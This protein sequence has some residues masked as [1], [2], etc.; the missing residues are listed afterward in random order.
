MI[1]MYIFNVNWF[2]LFKFVS[3][4][5]M[6]KILGLSKIYLYNNIGDE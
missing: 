5:E 4:M 1:N 3:V 6:I 2:F